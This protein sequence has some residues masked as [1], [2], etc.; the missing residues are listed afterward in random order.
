MNIT[1]RST[2]T[3]STT[4]SAKPYRGRRV[5]WAEFY[6]LRPDLRPANDNR[7]SGELSTPRNYAGSLAQQSQQ[8]ATA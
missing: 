6:S 1:A 7:Q 2:S 4:E 8:L 5:S 3:T